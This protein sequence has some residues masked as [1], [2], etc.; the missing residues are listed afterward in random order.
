MVDVW[1]RREWDSG[2]DSHLLLVLNRARVGE[3]K[4]P[5]RIAPDGI[6]DCVTH[7]VDGTHRSDVSNKW[8]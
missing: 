8:I 3:S 1:G 5:S 6:Y 7:Y 2:S 4:A